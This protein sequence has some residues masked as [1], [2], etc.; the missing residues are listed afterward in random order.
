[1]KIITPVVLGLTSARVD[2]PDSWT[3]H[4]REKAAT[5]RWMA[6]NINVSLCALKISSY[7]PLHVTFTIKTLKKSE[8]HPCRENLCEPT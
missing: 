4:P 1:M 7:S 5:A 8:T 6:A 2:K 3:P